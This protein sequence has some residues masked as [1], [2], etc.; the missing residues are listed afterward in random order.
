MV[1]YPEIATLSKLGHAFP[2]CQ[3]TWNQ[4]ICSFAGKR[5]IPVLRDSPGQTLTIPTEGG[6][7]ATQNPRLS[8]YLLEQLRI[9]SRKE[10]IFLEL[11]L[12]ME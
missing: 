8:A 1:W 12:F 6:F 3:K 2:D 9:Q 7:V 11:P 10:R 4:V 5:I